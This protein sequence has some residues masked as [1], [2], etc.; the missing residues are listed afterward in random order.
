MNP[1]NVETGSFGRILK[2]IILYRVSRQGQATRQTLSH[3]EIF[4]HVV[5]GRF[6]SRF[7]NLESALPSSVYRHQAEQAYRKVMRVYMRVNRKW[8]ND[9]G[10]HSFWFGVSP[11]APILGVMNWGCARCAGTYY[12]WQLI[13]SPHTLPSRFGFNSIHFLE[14]LCDTLSSYL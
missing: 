3:H 13:S 9:A 10:I 11:A 5:H 4:W 12:T 14:R 8:L 7:N 2:L 1:L 6:G